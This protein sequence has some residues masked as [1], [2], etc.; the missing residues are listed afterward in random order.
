MSR[1]AVLP[2]TECGACGLSWSLHWHSPQALRS[3][4]SYSRKTPKPASGSA[5]RRGWWPDLG[6]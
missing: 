4:F 2:V 6:S 5:D 3:P 1:N